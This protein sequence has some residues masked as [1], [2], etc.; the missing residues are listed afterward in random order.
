MNER[1][2]E[3]RAGTVMTLPLRHRNHSTLS[4]GD[5]GLGRCVITHNVDVPPLTHI[6]ALIHSPV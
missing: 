1:E 6:D 4:V 2:G 3:R 5:R